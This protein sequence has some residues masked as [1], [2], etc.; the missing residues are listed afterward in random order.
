[1]Y[2]SSVGA[3]STATVSVPTG[4][5]GTYVYALT[6][7]QDASSTTCSNPQVDSETV[8]VNSLPTA[9]TSGT[10][11]VCENGTPPVITF[12]GATGVAPYTFTYTINGGAQ[13]T[14]STTG[15]S[16]SATV[17]VPTGTPGSYV[18]NLISVQDASSTNCV[19]PQAD[20]ETIIVNPLPTAT[21][22]GSVDVCHNDAFPLVTFTGATGTAPYTFTYTINGG[23]TQTVSSVGGS[24][25]VT[26]PVSTAT[27]GTYVYELTGVR[28]GSSSTC[29]NPQ[30]GTITVIVYAYPPIDA[31]IDQLICENS[32]TSVSA[33]NPM[34]V[35]FYWNN[36]VTDGVYFSPTQPTIYTVTADNHGCLSTDDIFIDIE[37]L[38]TISF[39]GDTLQGCVP[40]VVNFT[41]T[42]SSPYGL[43]NCVWDFG[44]GNQ[45]V[46][47]G[48]ASN[49]FA[50]AG[51][52]SVT[53]TATS[54][55]GCVNSETYANY[56]YVEDYP[57]ISFTPAYAHINTLSTVVNYQN[58]TIGGSN[59]IWN[60][61]D[62]TGE[63]T[64]VHP[65]HTFPDEDQGFYTVQLIASSPIGCIDTAY[66]YVDVEEILIYYIPNTFTPDGDDY[67]ETFKPVFTD[68]YDPYSYTMLIFNRWGEVIWESHDTQV[69]W[70]GNY[71][72]IPVQDGT[73]TWKIEFKTSFDDERIM[74]VGHVNV[75]R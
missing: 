6:S 68:G 28:D 43:A 37:V 27:P 21:V 42:S 67:N 41:S 55:N 74:D 17:T 62:G 59:Y 40:L 7:V 65:T 49:T 10:T 1:M 63:S 60:F 25:T 75:I 52:Y 18:Y 8:I 61:G 26:V 69:G 5:P 16:S 34:N 11:D 53:L 47:C 20:S 72:G 44:D 38:P 70:N 9:S 64:E 46:G 23:A 29:S 30:T 45:Y 48:A 56:V 54:N 58:T 31:G 57:D 22:A 33:T 71:A 24:S 50:D 15:G 19:N 12:T 14:V 13:L 3:S 4:T 39:Y 73:Y 36:N 51:Y 32:S 2:V 35:P 66:G